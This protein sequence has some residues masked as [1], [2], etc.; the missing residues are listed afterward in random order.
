MGRVLLGKNWL[1]VSVLCIVCVLTPA[2]S[3]AQSAQERQAAAEAYDRGTSALLAEDFAGAARYFEAAHRAAP[4]APALIQAVRSH[5]RA[6]NT[7]RAATLALRLLDLYGDEEMART[8]GEP[9][10]EAAASQYFRVD[11]EC[12]AECSMDLDGMLVGHPSVFLEASS[13]HAVIVHFEHGDREETVIGEAGD[14]IQL[15]FEAPPAPP[16]SDDP[17]PPRDEPSR[18]G[19]ETRSGISP[20]WFVAGLAFTLGATGAAVWSGMDTLSAA[21]DYEAAPT[22]EGL[23][24]G[25]DLERRS[26]ILGGVAI[27]LGLTT[28]VLAIVTDWGGSDDDEE[29]ASAQAV[30]A[31]VGLSP[32]GGTIVLEGRF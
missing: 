13:Q 22:T 3:S 12:D 16:P 28:V 11:I 1:A 20:A 9:I 25:R 4:G 27:G 32:Q 31:T 14:R 8:I 6:G 18:P 26:N 29:A 24:E 30:H 2:R 17:L 19:T 10:V 23:S 21:D 7:L 15:T 5:D